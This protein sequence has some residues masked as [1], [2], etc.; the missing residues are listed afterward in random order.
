MKRSG[1]FLL[2]AVSLCT[3]LTTSACGGTM[4]GVRGAFD[5]GDYPLAKSRIADVREPAP[6]DS[7]YV[8]YSLYRGLVCG[9]LGDVSCA[10]SFLSRAEEAHRRMPNA[11]DEDDQRRLQVGL[12]TYV[13]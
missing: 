2:V 5:Q 9:A 10:K 3:L 11:L 4:R 6:T 12:E 13:K 1:D 7:S 8:S